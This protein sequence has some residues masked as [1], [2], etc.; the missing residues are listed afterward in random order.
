MGAHELHVSMARS[1]WLNN[2]LN[3]WFERTELLT[4]HH[5]NLSFHNQQNW[6]AVPGTESEDHRSSQLLVQNRATS[7]SHNLAVESPEPIIDID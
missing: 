1:N 4:F 2:W 5:R 6:S 3:N 7:Q